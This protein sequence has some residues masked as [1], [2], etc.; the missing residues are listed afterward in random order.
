M[1]SRTARNI[2]VERWG[3]SFLSRFSLS[4]ACDFPETATDDGRDNPDGRCAGGRCRRVA[5]ASGQSHG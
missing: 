3:I 1:F 4:L 5:D 2:Y